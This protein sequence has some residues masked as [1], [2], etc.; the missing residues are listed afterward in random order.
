MILTYD[1]RQ[2]LWEW[3]RDYLDRE[4]FYRVDDTHPP[5][6]GKA[7]GTTYHWQ[8]YTRRATYNPNFA[9]AVGLMF[10]DQF[11]PV[12]KDKPF[13]ICACEPSGPP[14]GMTIAAVGRMLGV[15]VN[16]FLARREAKSFGFNNWF[17]GRVLPDVPVM[18]VDDTAGSAPFMR[19]AAARIGHKL[20]LPLHRNYF[21]ILNK[22][23]RG[24]D[25]KSQHTENYLDGELIA[26]F[27]MNNFCKR[28]TEFE[29]RYGHSPKWSGLVR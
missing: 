6:P 20:A 13:Q 21:T 1:K 27:T 22:V 11:Q 12:F 2:A 7:P 28:V 10:W 24:F 25:K 5:I 16:V 26:L 29:E 3:C 14:I 18:I 17:D 4:V 19:H 8:A 15:K 9:H 23:G